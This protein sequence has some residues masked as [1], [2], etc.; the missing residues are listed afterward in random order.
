MDKRSRYISYP[1]DENGQTT[2]EQIKKAAEMIRNGKIKGVYANE[3]GK[4]VTVSADE[5][6]GLVSQHGIEMI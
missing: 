3:G 4:L 1:T 2:L 6:K 5:I